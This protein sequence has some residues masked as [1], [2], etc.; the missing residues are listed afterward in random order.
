MLVSE[1]SHIAV[2]LVADNEN[3]PLPAEVGESCEGVAVPAYACRVVRIA[4]YKHPALVVGYL[5]KIVEV[6][7][8]STV[9][10]SKRVVYH[11][12]PVAFRHEPERMIDRRLDDDL[13]ILLCEDVHSQSYSLD[14]A[15]DERHP[16]SPYF[17]LVMAAYPVDD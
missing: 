17:P 12:A 9:A 13:L 15:R 6:H 7:H 2:Y 1:D 10:L 14:D 11:L 3:V 16:F 4:Q 8:V 5:L